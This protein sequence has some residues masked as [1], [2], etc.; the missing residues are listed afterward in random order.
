M[1]RQILKAKSDD[2]EF[3]SGFCLKHVMS[4]TL[5]DKPIDFEWTVNI[6]TKKKNEDGKI[7]KKILKKSIRQEGMKMKD[8]GQFYKFLS[9]KKRLATLLSR[10]PALSFLRAEIENEFAHYDSNRSKVFRLVYLIEHEAYKLR[11]DLEND[12]NAEPKIKS[13]DF[14][15]YIKTSLFQN[16]IVS[17]AS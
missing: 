11:P 2:R 16:A 9:D 1:A 17:L 7:E 13:N 14:T 4:G 15:S 6:E 3:Q 5:L 8:Y 12:A 10:L